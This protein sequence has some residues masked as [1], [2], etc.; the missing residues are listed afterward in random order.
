MCFPC[1]HLRPIPASWHNFIQSSLKTWRTLYKIW[2]RPPATLILCQQAF[3]KRSLIA[4]PQIVNMSLLLMSR[5]LPACPETCCHQT[6]LK[7]KQP[8]QVHRPISHFLFLSKIIEKALH[9]LKLRRWQN[10]S[11]SIAGSQCCFWHSRPQHIA[12]ENSWKNGWE[13]WIS[14]TSLNYT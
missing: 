2:Y 1:V 8:R 6:T 13:F 11:L 12:A 5:C 9:P 7:R 14:T 10:Y 3:S 4:C